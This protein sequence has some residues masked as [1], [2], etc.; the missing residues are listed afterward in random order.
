VYSSTP[1][2]FLKYVNKIAG[3]ST[4]NVCSPYWSHNL[5]IILSFFTDPNDADMNLF[6]HCMIFSD[7]MYS[8]RE[9]YEAAKIILLHIIR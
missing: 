4:C 9:C 8:N 7:D 6:A 3:F 2:G 5:W 1:M